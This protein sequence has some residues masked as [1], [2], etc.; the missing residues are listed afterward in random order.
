MLNFHFSTIAAAVVLGCGLSLTQPAIQVSAAT[1][2]AVLVNNVPITTNDIKRRA[3]FVKLRR[4]K[5]NSRSIA[6]QELI[7]E[8][9]QLQEAKRIGVRIS[10]KQVDAAYLRFAKRNKMPVK[11]LGRIMSQSG[12]TIRGFK[13]F[14]RAQM[15]WQSV[16]AAR[17]RAEGRQTQSNNAL[18]YL[19]GGK[20]GR[21]AQTTEY[22]IQQIVFVVPRAKQKTGIKAR[23]AEANNFRAS[24]PGCAGSM[25][26][27]KKL[28]DVAVLDKGRTQA[29][30]L[31]PRWKDELEKTPAGKTTRPLKTEKGVELLAVCNTR[32]VRSS[33]QVVANSS[34]D[35]FVQET[36]QDDSTAALSKKYMS[37][38]KKIAVIKNR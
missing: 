28:R 13:Q 11:A 6:K 21:A 2:I 38:L 27:A 19:H 25:N 14:I 16:L 22:T 15:T 32:K 24:F 29:H 34:T 33:K 26:Y 20:G 5:G 23:M 10:Q 3:A 36:Q 4:M 37:E 30:E 17:A 35:V 18:D 8:A 31:P 12:V 9:M 1:K 7:D